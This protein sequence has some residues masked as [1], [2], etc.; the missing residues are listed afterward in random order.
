MKKILLGTATAGEGV[1]L[2]MNN[3][4]SV[5]ILDFIKLKKAIIAEA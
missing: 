3:D 1:D 4:K 5:N 2:D